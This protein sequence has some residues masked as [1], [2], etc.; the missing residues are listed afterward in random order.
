[1]IKRL[2]ILFVVLY[3][4]LILTVHAKE[5]EQTDDKKLYGRAEIG[6]ISFSST[7]QLFAL[8]DKNNITDT[9]EG[10]ADSYLNFWPMAAL[11]LRYALQKDREIYLGTPFLDDGR[12]GITL[13]MAQAF[14]TK[15]FLDVSV[16]AGGKY[17]WKDPYLFQQ[18]RE[19]TEVYQLGYSV[20]YRNIM[21]SDFSLSYRYKQIN[22]V[23]DVIGKSYQDLRRDGAIHTLGTCYEIPM[24]RNNYITPGLVFTRA[25]IEGESNSYIGYTAELSY[26]WEDSRYYL[27]IL[28]SIGQNIYDAAHP[29]F[30]ETREENTYYGAVIFTLFDLFGKKDLYGRIGIGYDSADANID[31]FDCHTIISGLSIGYFF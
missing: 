6:V 5:V 4:I 10:E 31:F 23:D 25:G 26:T 16:F 15:D 9:L 29:V 13:G 24:D 28:A 21:N 14:D 2:F 20:D 1:M 3:A 7:D 8:S 27:D 22:V 17:V 18:E 30:N 11:E 12:G 19:K